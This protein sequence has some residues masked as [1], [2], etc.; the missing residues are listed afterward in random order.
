MRHFYCFYS[1]ATYV[2]HVIVL[3]EE[4]SEFLRELVGPCSKFFEVSS[5]SCLT[6]RQEFIVFLC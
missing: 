3:N 2:A 6:N 1:N 5:I 4:Q